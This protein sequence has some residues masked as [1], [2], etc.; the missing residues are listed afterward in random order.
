[1]TNSDD[2]EE[3]IARLEAADGDS[4]KL[5]LAT[6][7][8]VIAIYEPMIRT[9]L[10]AAVMPH[11]FDAQILSVLL[12][13]DESK[14]D[15]LVKELRELPMVETFA[16]RNGWNVHE[17]TR[18]ALRSRLAEE[19]P[20]QFQSLSARAANYFKSDDPAWQI[21]AVYHRLLAEPDKAVQDLECLWKTWR[22]AGRYE[23]LQALGLALGELIRSAQ[24]MPMARAQT[25]V[26]F[27]SISRGR[28]PLQTVRDLVTEALD[29]F[30]EF[31]HLLGE[32]DAR[33]Q[34]G[35]TLMAEGSLQDA[36]NQFAINKR[37][38]KRLLKREP[39]KADWQSELSN[40]CSKIGSVLQNQGQLRKALHEYMASREIMQQLNKRDPK[41]PEWLRELSVAHNNLGS[42]YQAQGHSQKALREYKA[43]KKIMQFLTHSNSENAGWQLD[44]SIAHNSIGQILEAQGRSTEALPEYQ[45]SKTIMKRLTKRDP[46]NNDWL[47]ELSVSHNKVGSIYQ[48]QRHWAR[49]MREYVSAKEIRLELTKRDPENAMWQRDLSVSLNRVGSLYQDKGELTNALEE[50]K[51]STEIMQQLTEQDPQ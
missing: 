7:D 49:A 3:I 1:M 27:S 50:Y 34:L 20:A 6:L 46:E 15:A 29:L 40:A 11:W 24:M 32:I 16:V 43:D 36:L 48:A 22:R 30:R 12:E 41:N 14:T 38:A 35:E 44:L 13:I 18:L 25:L 45:A 8:I 26:C 9:A 37:I 4:T 39:E 33:D 19:R 21:E 51:A 47:R 10:E 5:S 28:L 2:F 42:I 23:P 31:G 17:A